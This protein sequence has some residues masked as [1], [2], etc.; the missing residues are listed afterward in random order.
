MSGRTIRVIGTTEDRIA[1]TEHRLKRRLPPSYR[2]WILEN[3]G[4]EIDIVRLFP[5]FDDRDARKTWD[6]IVR[7]YEG[8]WKE[9][10]ENVADW[11]FESSHLLPIGTY[12]NGDFC[13][14]DYS[15]IGPD[16]EVPVILWSHETGDTEPKATSFGE[17][18]MKLG[19]GAYY[20]D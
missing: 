1:E 7:N 18:L 9:W 20:D 16:G 14:L 6:S 15:E 10:L 12:N 5:V 11:G 2:D 19:S 17:F 4:K 8:N 13:C 3:N